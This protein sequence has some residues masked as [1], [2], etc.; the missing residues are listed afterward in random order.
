MFPAQHTE[1]DVAYVTLSEVTARPIRLRTLCA[2][3]SV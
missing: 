3:R 2:L 1:F